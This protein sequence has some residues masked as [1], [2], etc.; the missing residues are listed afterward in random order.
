MFNPGP[1]GTEYAW[2]INKTFTN[3]TDADISILFLTPNTISYNST[4]EDPFFLTGASYVL[5]VNGQNY[6]LY[7]PAYYVNAMGCIEQ[8]RFCNP[9][10]PNLCTPYTAYLNFQDTPGP[11]T[12]LNYNPTQLATAERIAAGLE[13]TLTYNSVNNRRGAA[14]LASQTVSDLLQTENLP[15]DQWRI[16]VDNW[17]A[18]SLA[19]LQQGILEFA[20]GPS[21]PEVVPFVHFPEDTDTARMCYNQLV[22]LPSGYVNFDFG[23]ILVV[24]LV[25]VFVFA[26]ALAF[27]WL[28]AQCILKWGRGSG[29][30]EWLEDG[31]FQLLKHT[32]TARNIDWENEDG[33]LPITMAR[34]QPV[35]LGTGANGVNTANVTG[36]QNAPGTSS[37][38]QGAS[39]PLPP[40]RAGTNSSGNVGTG[41]GATQSPASSGS[42]STRQG[43]DKR[44]C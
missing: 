28:A 9:R 1:P 7:A 11:L 42:A 3:R 6:S 5:S 31:Q 23:A 39:H 21:D 8:H 15:V 22:Q 29:L 38:T 25:G 26:A 43:P 34:L 10:V 27:E 36:N 16:E 35:E 40:T 2:S 44:V 14:L 4:V 18:V 41:S 13:M 17:F 19:K 37:L 33:D 24:T 12:T 32:Y 30:K 20:A